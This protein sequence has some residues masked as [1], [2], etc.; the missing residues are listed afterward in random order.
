MTPS[1]CWTLM[2]AVLIGAS[3]GGGVRGQTAQRVPVGAPDY[4]TCAGLDEDCC[5]LWLLECNLACHSLV[6]PET[7]AVPADQVQTFACRG[8]QLK[9]TCKCEGESC[10]KKY[11]GASQCQEQGDGEYFCDLACT[12]E[13]VDVQCP[14]GKFPR[15][16]K[17]FPTCPEHTPRYKCKHF[18]KCEPKGGQSLSLPPPVIEPASAAAVSSERRNKNSGARPAAS[19][20]LLVALPFLALLSSG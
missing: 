13:E 14:V 17:S 10:P 4:G 1:K 18:D 5:H 6:L 19:A 2:L 20:A 16:V 9:Y 7:P 11:C 3:L 15:F 12:P 8:Q